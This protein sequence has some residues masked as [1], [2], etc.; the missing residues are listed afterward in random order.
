MKEQEDEGVWVLR[1]Q[2][3]SMQ[4]FP[5]FN[6][7]MINSKYYCNAAIKHF[8]ESLDIYFFKF[9]QDFMRCKATTVE[10][11]Q[12]CR[13][14]VTFDIYIVGWTI[15]PSRRVVW[16]TICIFFWNHYPHK[17]RQTYFQS[18]YYIIAN[19]KVMISGEYLFQKLWKSYIW[20][21]KLGENVNFL[22]VSANALTRTRSWNMHNMEMQWKYEK[23]V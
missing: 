15:C 14:P 10:S 5:L 7:S 18:S 19:G 9:I 2:A 17:W 23:Q 12:R 6:W 3:A 16:N 4:L 11:I 22:S 1:C 21:Q 8:Q 20:N 13:A